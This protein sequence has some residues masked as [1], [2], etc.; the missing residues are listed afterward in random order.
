M[1]VTWAVAILGRHFSDALMISIL[2]L[3]LFAG[4]L[5]WDSHITVLDPEKDPALQ[6]QQSFHASAKVILI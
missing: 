6:L 4:S 1:L 2:V 5:F 3:C